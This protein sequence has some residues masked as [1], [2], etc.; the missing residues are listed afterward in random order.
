MRIETL[1][2]RSFRAH[3]ASRLSF[4]PKVNLLHGPNG[5]GKTNIL[6]AIH[7]LCLSKNFLPAQDA[8]ALRR[9]ASFFEI[10]A[11]FAGER[12]PALTARLAYEASAGKRLLVNGAPLERL[13]DIVGQ[14]PVVVLAPEDFALTAGPPEERRRFL[15]NT[16]SQA[17]PAYLADL[18]RY[19]RALR[20]R[21]ALLQDHRQPGSSDPAALRAWTTELVVL[22]ARLMERR[23]WFV[24]EF[25]EHLQRAYAPLADLGEMPAIEYRT[26]VSEED[27]TGGAAA[28]EAAFD[29]RLARLASRERARGRTL[30]G[31]HRDDLRFTLGAFDVRGY[32][33]QG[34][35]RTFA[36]A[37]KLATFSYLRE[38]L[39]ET[40][41]LLLDDV[42]GILDPERTRIILDMLQT[43]AIGQSIITAARKDV[44]RDLVDF[45]AAEHLAARVVNGSICE[46]D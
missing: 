27:L 18:L 31:P 43:D 44:F 32:A 25:S 42:F 28:I 29:A 26:A 12:R 2:L 19:R 10:E 21:N 6:E 34:Q 17:R 20:Q 16:L 23:Q 38:Q 36:L 46:G 1:R 13:A 7:Y 3:D 39:E 30:A 11:A 5:S 22:G 14:L 41:L 37:L 35:H 4:A 40:P 15:D 9:G 24:T 33:S 8:V 45:N